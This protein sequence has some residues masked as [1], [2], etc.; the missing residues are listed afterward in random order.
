[1]KLITI[2]IYM[3]QGLLL[4]ALTPLLSG[5]IRKFK[6]FFRG[7]TGPSVFQ[8]YY[9]LAKLFGKGQVLSR[10]SSFITV[11]GASI[12]LAAAIT[13]AF[14]IPVFYTASDNFPGNLFIIIFMLGIIKLM[15][16]LI[17]LDAASTFGGMGS[18]RE[19]F[20]SMLAEPVMFILIAFL[21]LETKSF[22]I[23][24]ISSINGIAN[25][26]ASHIIAAV[27]FFILIIAENARVPVDNPETH[28]ELTM[29]HEAMILDVSGSNLAFLELSSSIKLMV[30][31][32]IFI[33]CFVPYGIT[34]SLQAGTILV[35]ILLFC[36]KLIICSG[37]IA[38]VEANVAKFRLFRVPELL[39]TAFSFSMLA[40]TINYFM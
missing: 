23:S 29:V 3:I 2:V 12:S 14:F 10:H 22:N 39:A 37:I 11:F 35:S 16:S 38:Y 28:L 8:P 40:I 1:M 24:G 27:A 7:Y 30:F 4:I 17:G 6:A 34:A 5:I 36:I 20:I 13:T 19:L 33:N 15:N 26:N 25:Y 31:F 18:S 32:A 9:D 21:F